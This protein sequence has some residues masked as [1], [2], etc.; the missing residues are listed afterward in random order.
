MLTFPRPSKSLR[1]VRR[2]LRN[3]P[4]LI[5]ILAVALGWLVGGAIVAFR[6]GVALIQWVFYGTADERLYRAAA[7]LP[8]WRLALAPVVGG[9]LVGVMIRYLMPGRRPQGVAHV[10]EASVAG[11]GRMKLLVGL[12]T[13][14]CSATTIGVGG[15]VGRE[16][17]AVHLGGTL[18]GWMSG[19]L[20]LGRR[21]A[22]S[23]LGCGVAAAV[24]AS[25]NAPI[26]G[27][28]FAHEVVVGHYA[29]SAF[30]PVVISSVTATMVSRAWFGDFPAFAV[31]IF[32]MKSWVELPAFAAL[33]AAA[34]IV[35]VVLM[36]AIFAADEKLGRLPVPHFLHPVIGGAILGAIACFYPQVLGVGYDITSDVLRG[37]VPLDL[38][39]ILL[40]AKLVATAACLGSGFAGGIFG[41]SLVLG[42]LLGGSFGAA[43]TTFL[44][45]FA[46]SSGAYALVGMGA[47][48]SAVLG[49]PISTT[50]IMFELTGDYQVTIAVMTASVIA[51]VMTRQMVGTSSFFAWQLKRRGLDVDTGDHVRL[52]KEMT[53]RPLLRAATDR[54]QSGARLP[55][56]R[57]CLAASR[58]GRLFV[59]TDQGRL[60]GTVTLGDLAVA[61]FDPS[62]D[63]LVNAVDV[64]DTDPPMIAAD[65]D[66]GS[67]LEVM[68]ACGREQVAVVETLDSRILVG[69]VRKS[70]ILEAHSRAMSAIGQGGEGRG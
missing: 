13:V 30:A 7:M 14:L 42:A 36:R 53:V 24:A 8:W 11:N 62:L 20:R 44:P 43:A 59:T 6:E 32:H 4:L 33:G 45:D 39:A 17:P 1:F 35:A 68:R 27:A 16:G 54:V 12:S 38:L 46:S 26:A 19:K 47:V 58:H 64:V 49:A 37:L 2:I 66:I 60:V 55:E 63:D 48:A 51:S 69:W 28:L 50:L 18:A 15:S 57:D 65:D 10:I 34:A 41:P 25:F 5:G 22:R 3:D 21:L 56:I 29:L 9:L 52:M 23:F 61:A 67:A 70:D 31:P 40:L